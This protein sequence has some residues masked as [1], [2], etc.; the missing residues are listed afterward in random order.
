MS[1]RCCWRA[2]A[3]ALVA[4]A[5]L[6]AA[7]GGGAS[8]A[9][10]DVARLR[11]EQTTLAARAHSA[12][13]DLY[14]VQTHLGAERARLAIL[15]TQVTHVRAQEALV[16]RE[17]AIA[18][19]AHA[20]S[21][22]QL[23]QRLRLLYEQGQPDPVAIVLGAT[24]LDDAITGI[25]DL[26]RAAQ[27]DKEMSRQTA[28]TRRSL[29]HLSAELAARTA[30]LTAL[31]QQSA[32][33]VAALEQAQADRAALI[34]T[35]R[36]KERMTQ[37]QIASLEAAA[38]AAQSKTQQLTTAAPAPSAS[39]AGAPPEPTADAPA[40]TAP[41]APSTGGQTLSVVATGYSL[42]GRTATG[43]PVGWGV[44]AVDPS[45]IPL[46]TH[47]T[48]PG[49][50]EAVAADTGGGVRGA[51]IDLWFPTLAQARAWGRRTVTVTLH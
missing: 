32:A 4:A 19:H 37:S 30:Q 31:E 2:L 17:V 34:A 33:S 12:L 49:Y 22:R 13:L 11:G 36:T 51:M 21:Q 6:L 25:D 9:P 45:V 3:L 47:M 7:G 20:V 39:S 48:V 29:S 5:A 24:S 18:A 43:L 40:P 44:A 15:Q 35:L 27:Q 42:P 26:N 14:S 41:A 16:R 8:P 46:G 28:T 38:Q 23:A 50:G 1:P 10:P